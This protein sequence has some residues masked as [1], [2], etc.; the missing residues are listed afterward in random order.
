MP[1]LAVDLGRLTVWLPEWQ[2][3]AGVLDLKRPRGA[4]TFRGGRPPER[5]LF[6]V[7]CGG[8]FL[9]RGASI[10]RDFELSWFPASRARRSDAVA[11]RVGAARLRGAEV[12]AK[13]FD[14]RAAHDGWDFVARR[15]GGLG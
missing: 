2:R 10:E 3:C 13:R 1:P 11:A 5:L 14:L 4:G 15:P 8:S 12:A 6:A 7:T 9:G